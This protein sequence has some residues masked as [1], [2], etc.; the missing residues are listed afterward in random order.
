[1]AQL[2]KGT[3]AAAAAAAAADDASTRTLREAKVKLR[4]LRPR[5]SELSQF[6]LERSVARHLQQLT[7]TPWMERSRHF[8][9]E[10]HFFGAIL[11]LKT[12]FLLLSYLLHLN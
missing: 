7:A 11:I 8:K 6:F 2:I 12:L 9:E 10:F 5:R 4:R 1:M 3:R